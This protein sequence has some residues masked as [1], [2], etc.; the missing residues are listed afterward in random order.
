MTTEILYNSIL[1]SFRIT[2]T[3]KCKYYCVHAKLGGVARTVCHVFF[4]SSFRIFFCFGG[5]GGGGL[6][7][8]DMDSWC[9]RVPLA[10]LHV[11][12]KRP[13]MWYFANQSSYEICHKATRKQAK[14]NKHRRTEKE[15]EIINLFFVCGGGS[16][17]SRPCSSVQFY[18]SFLSI[19]PFFW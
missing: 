1:Y 7:G 4:V 13:S 10:F 15:E 9:L 3:Y 2:L 8:D 16:E 19:F 6:L 11:R 14:V 17:T 18:A 12:K 5:V